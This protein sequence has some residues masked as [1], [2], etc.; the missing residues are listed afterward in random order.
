MRDTILA[1]IVGLL[2]IG[3]LKN[4]AVGAYLWAW[5]S[6]MNPHKLTYGFAYSL[7]FAQAAAI[8]TLLSVVASKNKRTPPR[9]I[10]MMILYA[11]LFWMTLTSFFALGDPAEVLERWIFVMKIQF[12]LIVTLMVVQTA[13][14]IRTLIWVVTMSVCFFGIKG[15]FWTVLTGGGGRVWG[16]PGLLE[17]NNELAVGLVMLLPILYFLRQTEKHKL[18]RLLL[19]GSMALVTFS[20]LGSQSRGALLALLAMAFVLGIKGKYPVRTSLL[21]GA[22]VV[23]AIAF[24]PDTWVSRMETINTYQSDSSAMSRIW[25]WKTMFNAAVDRPL[26]G[27]GF[28]ADNLT[29]FQ[30]YTPIGPE[31]AEFQGLVYVA[32][33]IY[34]Q[35][36]GE[37]GFV[38]FGLYLALWGAVWIRAGHIAK[39]AVSRPDLAEWLPMLMRMSQVSLVGFAAGGAFLSL[40]YLDLPFYVAAYVV[41]AGALLNTPAGE[42][43]SN[44]TKQ[45][46]NRKAT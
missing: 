31:F 20:I 34:F 30:R 11:L 17:G 15:G 32:H 45:V 5:L 16:P 4:P 44:L 8:I 21:L 38:G 9:D 37:H 42:R 14:Q 2:L 10:I 25:T 7:P 36:L 13:S 1:A 22:F 26:V 29:V 24:M 35:M 19:T 28:R 27:A 23:V 40:A 46:M 39:A 12:M 41:L 33:S 43:N 18:V 3:A 6:L